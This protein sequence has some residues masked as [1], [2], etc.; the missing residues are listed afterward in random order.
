MS[1]RSA[2][3]NNNWKF[4]QIDSKTKKKNKLAFA[5]LGLLIFL[6]LVGQTVRFI[7]S[8]FTPITDTGTDSSPYSLDSNFN[9]NFVLKSTPISLVN[10]NPQEKT[11]TIVDIPED[12][13][14]EVPQGFG[15]WQIRAV[16]EL[17]ES[18]KGI[19]GWNLLEKTMSNLFGLPID[20]FL[21]LE[22]QSD[23][24]GKEIID[25][26]RQNP[27]NF[28]SVLSSIE[29]DFT[30]VELIKL[31]LALSQVRFDKVKTLDLK[32]FKLLEPDK[33][34]DG[35]PILIADPVKLDS[36]DIDFVDRIIRKEQLSIAVF[37][38]TD[39]PGLAQKAARIIKNIGGNV[40]VTSNISKKV[41]STQV[42]TNEESETS[43]RLRQI[44]ES[45]CNN[46]NTCD[47][48]TDETEI[49]NSRA[50]INVVVGEDFYEKF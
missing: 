3:K 38:A 33:L 11:I 44:F 17:G 25:S 39:Q 46:N 6:L 5:V 26:L 16:Y 14:V 19:G 30:P 47:K 7:N 28:F 13:Y 8:L 45:L 2:R 29:S 21:N 42:L 36:A 32:R 12:I 24:S 50:K 10:F 22:E 43:K 27:L 18:K 37:N 35:T 15:S 41:K 9:V 31:K 23:K 1:K 20:G 48:I 4:N 34:G 40:I 49:N